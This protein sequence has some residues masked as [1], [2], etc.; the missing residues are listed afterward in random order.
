MVGQFWRGWVEKKDSVVVRGWGGDSGNVDEHCNHQKRPQAKIGWTECQYMNMGR[1][2][3]V[4]LTGCL[5]SNGG[6]RPH[7]G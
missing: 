1:S 5:P 4:V 6:L 2:V 7:R 3:A